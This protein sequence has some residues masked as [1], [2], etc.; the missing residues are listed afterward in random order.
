LTQTLLPSIADG[1]CQ[2]SCLR[3]PDG[4]LG[5]TALVIEPAKA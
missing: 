2:A 4:Q 3:I 1:G 5:N